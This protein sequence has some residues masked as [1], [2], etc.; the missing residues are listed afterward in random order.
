MKMACYFVQKTEDKSAQL[1]EKSTS[2]RNNVGPTTGGKRPRGSIRC[3]VTH[4]N[5]DDYTILTL[6]PLS[7]LSIFVIRK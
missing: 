1:N 2:K 7:K 4:C 6:L 5:T 3:V